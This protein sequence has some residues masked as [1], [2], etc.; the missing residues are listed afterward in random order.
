[1]NRT[2]SQIFGESYVC[3]LITSNPDD[4]DGDSLRNVEY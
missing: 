4:G 3:R 2:L 1:M